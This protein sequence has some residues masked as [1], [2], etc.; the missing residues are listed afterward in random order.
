M[1]NVSSRVYVGEDHIYAHMYHV[2]LYDG[3]LYALHY[4]AH[5][6]WRYK[7]SIVYLVLRLRVLILC[8][9]WSRERNETFHWCLSLSR[10]P[11]S[12]SRGLETNLVQHPTTG[13]RVSNSKT[14]Q[15]RTQRKATQ[16]NTTQHN[17]TIW[18]ILRLLRPTFSSNGVH[19]HS[20][21]KK[22]SP[23]HSIPS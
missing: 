23:I 1:N 4:S 22:H 13:H 7:S 16:L 10:L 2:R 11:A 5:G 20:R 15:N 19:F 8:S 21:N 14:Q 17:T 18:S 6:V 12:R 3:A 9:S